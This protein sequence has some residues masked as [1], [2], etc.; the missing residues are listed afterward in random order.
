[1]R[2]EKMTAVVTG[3]A[4]GMGKSTVQLFIDKGWFVGCYDINKNNL[5]AL[6][7]EINSE[8]LICRELD[9]SNKDMFEEAVKEF[10]NISN[11]K[12]SALIKYKPE[13]TFTVGKLLSYLIVLIITFVAVII[14]LD[15]FKN[16]LSLIISNLEIMLYNLFEKLKN[17]I[18]FNKDLK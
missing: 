7:E 13:S 16:P 9:V 4:S 3:G 18:L 6:E 15:T 12:R 8:N 10:S 1:M 14:I 2:L 17:L 11:N 5:N